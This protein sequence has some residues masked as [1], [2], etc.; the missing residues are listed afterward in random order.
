MAKKKSSIRNSGSAGTAKTAKPILKTTSVVV[1]KSVNVPARPK[2]QPVK[3]VEKP[4]QSGVMKT[5][6]TR[7]AASSEALLAQAETTITSAI[8]NLNTQMNHAMNA[9]AS[10]ATAGEGVGRPVI[11]TA[12][13][14][15]TTAMF[16]RLVSEVLDDQLAEM[17][18]PLIELRGDLSCEAEE[19]QQTGTDAGICRRGVE[20]LDHVLKLAGVQKYEP[21]VGE[22]FDSLIHLGVGESRREDLP[23]GTVAESLQ[24]GYRSSRGKVLVPAR[25][26]INRK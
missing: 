4:A 8:E 13:L 26:K 23:D 12:P 1:K 18:P 6:A 3:V 20:I 17:L 2:E 22:A 11:R 9:L 15:R 25:V 24:P 5:A 14:D 16:H 19:P 21:R 7:A 10:L